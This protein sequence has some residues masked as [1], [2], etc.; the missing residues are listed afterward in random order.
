MNKTD[1]QIRR[2]QRYEFGFVVP[3][4]EVVESMRADDEE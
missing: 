3:F 2:L 4:D 1:H